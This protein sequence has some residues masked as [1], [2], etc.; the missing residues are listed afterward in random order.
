MAPNGRI[1]PN[2]ARQSPDLPPDEPRVT[3]VARERVDAGSESPVHPV[4]FAPP[5]SPRRDRSHTLA[6]PPIPR[7]GRSRPPNCPAFVDS[8]H[9]DDDWAPLDRNDDGLGKFH[10]GPRL[11]AAPRDA[12]GVPIQSERL[13]VPKRVRANDATPRHRWRRWRAC[14]WW[15]QIPRP[16]FPPG[17]AGQVQYPSRSAGPPVRQRDSSQRRIPILIPRPCPP[18]VA[19]IVPPGRDKP[20]VARR[21]AN[22]ACRCGRL[23]PS[24]LDN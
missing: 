22:P 14:E 8:T 1:L 4:R 3:A 12:I 11:I 16:K 15:R 21:P 7:A 24:C 10:T 9:K 5:R 13:W 2:Q 20:M 6:S 19:E 17:S 23:F 18:L